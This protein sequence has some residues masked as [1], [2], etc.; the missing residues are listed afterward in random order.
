MSFKSTL[1]QS[2]VKAQKFEEFKNSP[3]LNGMGAARKWEAYKDYLRNKG[4]LSPA[5]MSGW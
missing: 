1:S 5:L 3:K 4:L 2:N